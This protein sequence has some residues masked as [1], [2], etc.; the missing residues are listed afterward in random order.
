MTIADSRQEM[1]FGNPDNIDDSLPEVPNAK[2]LS[3][4]A[5]NL[6][7]GN[8]AV[9]EDE[10]YPEGIESNLGKSVVSK[11][12]IALRE[13]TE[14]KRKGYRNNKIMIDGVWYSG[15]AGYLTSRLLKLPPEEAEILRL[16][17]IEGPSL[18][19]DVDKVDQP[20]TDGKMRA[21]GHTL[22]GK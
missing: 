11:L 8:T 10:S 4:Q 21:A 12:E 19:T 14:R 3:R 17:Y 5:A 20:Y 1:L 18:E 15:P 6:A 7:L 16:K 9:L 2:H 22:D 13:R